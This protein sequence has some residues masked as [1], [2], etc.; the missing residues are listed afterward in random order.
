MLAGVGGGGVALLAHHS[1][2]SRRSCSCSSA[3]PV[4]RSYCRDRWGRPANCGPEKSCPPCTRDATTKG[5][6]F[7]WLASFCS[8]FFLM[9]HPFVFLFLRATFPPTKLPL[10]NVRARSDG[11]ALISLSCRHK[12]ERRKERARRPVARDEGTASLFFIWALLSSLAS[13]LSLEG[14]LALTFSFSLSLSLSLPL[15]L[16]NNSSSASSAAPAGVDADALRT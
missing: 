1:C 11:S 6:S 16:S 9:P 8:A 10:R 7:F 13:S 2:C 14:S 4:R 5:E 15:S 12:N 3:S